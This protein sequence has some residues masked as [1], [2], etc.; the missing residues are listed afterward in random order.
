MPTSVLK[1]I[2]SFGQLVHRHSRHQIEL[3]EAM[4]KRYPKFT[5]LPM[6]QKHVLHYIIQQ[7]KEGNIYQRDIERY[8]YIRRSTA[9][10]ILK[11]LEK[12]GFIIR[13]QS[14]EDGRLKQLLVPEDICHAFNEVYQ[15]VESKMTELEQRV[16]HNISENELTQFLATLNKMMDNIELN[17]DK[18]CEDIHG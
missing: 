4:Q 10:T 12:Q 13:V 18:E 5:Q 7:T 11:S 9:S 3:D 2:R 1:Q 17:S 14:S 16:T 8:F 6:M 15:Q